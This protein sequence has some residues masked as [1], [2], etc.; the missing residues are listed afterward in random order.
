M[1]ILSE[2]VNAKSHPLKGKFFIESAEIEV[3][4]IIYNTFVFIQRYL[5]ILFEVFML[6]L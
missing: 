6:T 3:G 1:E 2:K 4:I 5:S